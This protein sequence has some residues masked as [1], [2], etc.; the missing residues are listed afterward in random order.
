MTHVKAYNA[1]GVTYDILRDFPRAIEAYKRALR[2]NPNLA[3]VQKT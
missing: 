2:L 1:M 3:Y